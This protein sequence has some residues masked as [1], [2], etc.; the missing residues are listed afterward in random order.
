[1]FDVAMKIIRDEFFSMVFDSGT[2]GDMF[3]VTSTK[4]KKII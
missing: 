3:D 2:T 4:D 1:M